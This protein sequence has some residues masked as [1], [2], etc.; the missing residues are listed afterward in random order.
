MH[1]GIPSI[2]SDTIQKFLIMSSR[3]SPRRGKTRR[4]PVVQRPW[5]MLQSGYLGR[6]SGGEEEGERKRG[7]GEEKRGRRGVRESDENNDMLRACTM[8]TYKPLTY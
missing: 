7:R 4:W 2:Q 3:P 1:M 6:R 8:L 5:P